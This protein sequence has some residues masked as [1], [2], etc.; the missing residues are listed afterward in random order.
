MIRENYNQ[1]KTRRAPLNGTPSQRTEYFRWVVC[2]ALFLP[3]SL[4]LFLSFFSLVINLVA[5]LQETA[6]HRQLEFHLLPRS[7]LLF[8]STYPS[9]TPSFCLARSISPSVYYGA[10]ITRAQVTEH[11]AAH[12]SA[13]LHRTSTHTQTE[14]RAHKL[15]RAHTYTHTL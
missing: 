5:A 13:G 9:F 12:N 8:H 15:T 7:L 1:I 14:A 4:S 3:P 2:A 10:L 6:F 11:C